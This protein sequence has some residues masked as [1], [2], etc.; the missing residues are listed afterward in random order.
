M[1]QNERKPWY[2][3]MTRPATVIDFGLTKAQ[4]E[5]AKE[6]HKKIIVMDTL[7]ECSWYPGM[8]NNMQKGGLTAGSFSIGTAGLEHW[9]GRTENLTGRPEDWW[10]AE[11]LFKDISF[12][13]QKVKEHSDEIMLCTSAADVRKAKAENKIG[14]MLDVQNAN[15][16][17]NEPHNLEY[18]YNLGL[19][20][21]QLTYNRQNFA[22]SGCMDTQNSGLSIWGK[23]LVE[24]LNQQNML[25]DTGH[26]K[27]ATLNDAID[28]SSKPIACSH[29][30]MSSRVNNPRSH[31]DKVLK[32]L[33]DKGGFFGIVS[34][35]GALNE[36][37]FCTV[38][39]YVDTIEAA[40]NLCGIDHVGFGTDFILGG[41]LE[42]ILNAPEW[43]QKA[44]EAS[45][46]Q[47][48]TMWP[49][50][51]GHKGMENNSGYPNLTR[52][53]IAKGYTDDEIAKLM[54]GNYLRLL[55]DT[56]G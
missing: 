44:A 2:K 26:C 36:T 47:G 8:L 28:A 40:V 10:T 15:F 45:G 14:F 27:P 35:P 49:W 51:D 4:E 23:E 31:P 6:L 42:E 19:R 5:R 20:R 37:P 32:K 12:V 25:V 21:L 46:V 24:R 43:G 29:A 9:Q 3:S 55:E 54:G 13:H 56:I 16:L 41:S 7:I 11:T 48:D 52:G 22:G 39:D 33:A 50:S 38:K 53:L 34:T 18:F 17:G 1:K 30:G